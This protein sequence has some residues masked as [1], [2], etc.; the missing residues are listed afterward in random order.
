MYSHKAAAAVDATGVVS[1]TRGPE[2]SVSAVCAVG[3]EVTE[4]SSAGDSC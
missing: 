1:V 2:P 3:A 4:V